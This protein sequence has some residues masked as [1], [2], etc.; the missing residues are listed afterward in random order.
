MT[1]P[2]DAIIKEGVER[3]V[4]AENDETETTEVTTVVSAAEDKEKEIVTVSDTG[5]VTVVNDGKTVVEASIVSGKNAKTATITINVTLSKEDE[6][7]DLE[8]K[9]NAIPSLDQLSDEDKEEVDALMEEYNGLSA[10]EKATI[11]SSSNKLIASKEQ[12]DKIVAEKES[13][14]Q[15]ASTTTNA[16]YSNSLSGSSN[17]SSSSNSG[18]SSKPSTTKP[19][20]FAMTATEIRN[21]ALDQIAKIDGTKY[22]SDFTKDNAG[23]NN[24]LV[25]YT[26]YSESKI[27]QDI[28][29][30]HGFI[31]VLQETVIMCM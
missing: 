4:K 21:Y 17:N 12:V 20:N 26:S 5:L 25:I 1:E 13:A 15:A 3:S 10:Q 19:K 6:I 11:G 27:K 23:W 8:E 30:V 31:T 28:K 16:A 29:I 22:R 7:A 24:P 9:I 14:S 2:K 18:S